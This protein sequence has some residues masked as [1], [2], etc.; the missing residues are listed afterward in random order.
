M[1][2]YKITRQLGD[3]TYG[4]VFHTRIARRGGVA[5]GGR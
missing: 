4:C 2:R 5:G 3:G 1:N